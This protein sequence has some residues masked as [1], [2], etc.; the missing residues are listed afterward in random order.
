MGFNSAFKGLMVKGKAVRVHAMKAYEESRGIV[1]SI[2]NLRITWSSALNFTYRLLYSREITSITILYEAGWAPEPIWLFCREE[3]SVFRI[4]SP[5]RS[6]SSIVAIPT[7]ISRLHTIRYCGG[8]LLYSKMA[9]APWTT[10]AR[11]AS[12]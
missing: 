9:A 10:V 11:G 6:S 5:D 3:K 4:R 1:P 8:I 2:F 12:T 7:A